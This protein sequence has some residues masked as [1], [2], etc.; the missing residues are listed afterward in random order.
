MEPEFL[1]EK[2]ITSGEVAGSPSPPKSYYQFKMLGGTKQQVCARAGEKEMKTKSK[3]KKKDTEETLR[4]RITLSIDPDHHAFIKNAGINASRFFDT[5]INALKKNISISEL[6]ITTFMSSDSDLTTKI[7]GP[8]RIRT[9]D[10][11]RVRAT[12]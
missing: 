10:L 6:Q 4:K 5:A 9:G 1:Q 2:L 12:S 7:D 11:R 8:V 3:T